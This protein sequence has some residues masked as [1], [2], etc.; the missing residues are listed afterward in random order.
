[1]N[2]FFSEYVEGSGNFNKGLEI[3]NAGR[4]LDLSTC[5]VRLYR[6]GASAPSTTTTLNA[7]TLA[8]DKTYMLCVSAQ[9]N[10]GNTTCDQVTGNIDFNG[11][12][13]L[14]IV[15][16]GQ[17]MDI[18]GQIG[19]DPGARWGSTTLGTENNTLRRKCAVTSGDTNGADAF[20]P[21]TEWDG[22]AIDTFDGLGE[23]CP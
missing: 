7:V 9:F 19:T 6:N 10:S 2:V 5:E 21:A 18:I 13:A 22:F 14:D 20:V 3:Y 8:T 16:G 23:H 1:M 11:D 17:T 12:D 15:C 4:S